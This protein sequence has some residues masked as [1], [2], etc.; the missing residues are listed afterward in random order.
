MYQNQ[1]YAK[2]CQQPLQSRFYA[3]RRKTARKTQTEILVRYSTTHQVLKPVICSS[4]TAFAF[5]LFAQGHSKPH[6]APNAAEE[7]RREHL[8]D[9]I[10]RFGVKLTDKKS[11]FLLYFLLI[12]VQNHPAVV[13]NDFAELS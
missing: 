1:R 11:D 13:A 5:R 3:P 10:F 4:P 7:R 12:C 6:L 2:L 8:A 9:F